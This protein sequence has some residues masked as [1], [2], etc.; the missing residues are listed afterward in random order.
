MLTKIKKELCR[1]VHRVITQCAVG[2]KKRDLSQGNNRI[3]PS[4]YLH[5]KA[6]LEAP[7]TLYANADI[8]AKVRIGAFS[9]IN[10]GTTL[11]YTTRVGRYCSIGK[12][13]EIGAVDHPIDW[14]SSSSIQYNIAEHFEYTPYCDGFAQKPFETP[15]GAVIGNDVW[16]GSLVFVKA[17]VTIGDGAIVAA[18]SVVTKDVPPYAIVGGVP[19]K[20]IRYR[21]DPQQIEKL[22]ALAWW[23][24][25]LD[26]LN[27]ID[28]E[29]IDRAIEQLSALR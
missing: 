7:V 15:E 19:A 28:F 1:V 23:E 3:A 24:Y 21:F 14:L 8:R 6:Q 9:Y 27:G 12:K 20:V 11:F 2:S 18:G 5:K 10:N 22:L 26:R 13:C 29:D 4:V 16:I 25:E 17:G